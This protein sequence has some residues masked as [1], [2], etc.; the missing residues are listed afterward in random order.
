[1]LRN[2]TSSIIYLQQ[3]GR[4][5]RRTSD[6]DKFVT[7]LDLIG[8]SNNNYS[9][10]QVLTANETADKRMLYHHVAT[11]FESV[12]P[13]IN[14]N[15]E[16][17]A[18][19]NIISSISS[20]FT[21]KTIL[22]KKFK[23]ELARYK[24]IPRLVDLYN[25][26]YL[27]EL[28][29]LQLLNKSFYEAFDRYYKTKYQTPLNNLFLRHFFRLITQFV[30]RGYDDFALKE[31][32]DLLKGKRSDNKLLMKILLPQ[33]FKD[34]IPSAINSNYNSKKFDLPEA[35]IIKKEGIKLNRQIITKL[36]ELNAYE[37]YLEHI[38]LI[39]LLATKENYQMK[40]FDL[41][42]KA[43]FL[44]AEGAS[45]C[46]M[47]AVGEMINHDKKVVYCTIKITKDDSPYD[48]H[49][50]DERQFVYH[51]QNSISKKSAENKLNNLLKNN[52]EFK[53]CAQFPHLGYSNT[54]FFNLGKLKL[55]SVSEVIKND[56]KKYNHE[57]TFEL[58]EEFPQEFL[59][60]RK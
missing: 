22:N 9:I 59:M 41:V 10:A 3:L 20:N 25:N 31:Y 28:D 50:I 36:K 38:E 11:S 17:K 58:K 55:V 5:L 53:I 37:L 15:I 16:E 35:F 39:E 26:P 34:G 19:E 8:N 24:Y 43:E 57:I 56:E 4:G 60:Y 7:V 29:L 45:D 48:N 51:T 14:V 30:F 12:S 47:N 44:F 13:F 21:V 49:I 32:S 27:H 33:E 46:Y 18:I 42:E 1:M 54:S 6:P 40:R 2:T 52:Y 23:E